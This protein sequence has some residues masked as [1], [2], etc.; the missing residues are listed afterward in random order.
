MFDS[1]IDI[2]CTILLDKNAHNDKNVWNHLSSGDCFII[3]S[4]SNGFQYHRRKSNMNSFSFEGII[5]TE[6]NPIF[7]LFEKNKNKKFFVKISFMKYTMVITQ[8]SR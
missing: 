1:C 4:S 8:S 7:I 5:L 6:S 3:Q 2:F